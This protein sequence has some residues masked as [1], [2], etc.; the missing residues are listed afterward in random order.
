MLYELI[1][2]LSERADGLEREAELIAG[3]LERARNAILHPERPRIHPSEP[4]T[5]R[6]TET[7]RDPSPRSGKKAVAPQRPASANAGDDRDKAQAR[8]GQIQRPVSAGVKLLAAQMALDGDSR[9]EIRLRLRRDFGV[10]DSATAV[11]EVLEGEPG[12]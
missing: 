11:S 5:G 6:A 2:T 12:S 9:D 4:I 3:I 10:T 7:R 1:L 8:S